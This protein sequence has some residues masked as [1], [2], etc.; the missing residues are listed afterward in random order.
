MRACQSAPGRGQF[1]A[2][3]LVTCQVR[4]HP[5]NWPRRPVTIEN[6]GLAG[7]K[8]DLVSALHP[9]GAAMNLKRG[10]DREW[11]RKAPPAGAPVSPPPTGN[12]H[13]QPPTRHATGAPTAA[14]ATR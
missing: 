13:G 2:G 8:I 3:H 10:I 7:G 9:C 12:G 1:L 6:V 11:T 5:G 14:A 4:N